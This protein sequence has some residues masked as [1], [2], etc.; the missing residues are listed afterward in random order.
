[1]SGASKPINIEDAEN[2]AIQIVHSD[3]LADSTV[4]VIGATGLIGSHIVSALHSLND[5]NR[6]NI[7]IV[8]AARNINRLTSLFE[9]MTDVSYKHC[10]VTSL[11]SCQELY[12]S[13]LNKC[14]LSHLFLIDA[15]SPSSP[16]L[17]SQQP[18][19]TMLS[20]IYG[21]TNLISAFGLDGKGDLTIKEIT[22]LYIS[23]SEVYGKRNGWHLMKESD[24]AYIDPTNPRSCYPSS[25]LAV[26]TLL[27]S[28]RKE[29]GIDERIARP[30]HV[31]GP[32]FLPTDNRVSADFF[33]RAIRGR[34]IQLRSTGTDMRTMIYIS[35][36]VS[37]ILSIMTAGKSGQA[38]NVTNT[39]N[40]VSLH[41][42]S[43]MI[44][45]QGH[46]LFSAPPIKQNEF[47]SNEPYLQ[48]AT[49]LSDQK[50]RSLGWIP[51]VSLA[52]G[53]SR[54]L[55]ALQKNSK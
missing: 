40:L 54:T 25:K 7:R 30:S 4:I 11:P 27:V 48:R 21:V 26:E 39:H 41:D 19:E 9:T 24:N 43:Q 52:K 51:R 50:L 47:Q 42:F 35:D 14:S 18:V 44:A 1:M 13:V 12:K 6:T 33:A 8:A 46:V 3:V 22:F 16:R 36:C 20:N 23:S 45:Q 28:M 32:G 29:Y 34:T 55:K 49:A 2:A 31:F 17:Y 37:G 10:D 53:I 5:M 15:A 38:Y